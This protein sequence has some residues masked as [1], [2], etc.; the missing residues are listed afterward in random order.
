[1]NLIIPLAGPD[2]VQKNGDIKPLVPYLGKPLL[3]SLLRLRCYE[4][5][6]EGPREKKSSLQVIAVLQAKS[7]H[8]KVC[9][10]LQD[11]YPQTRFVFLS[12]YSQGALYSAV[13]GSSMVQDTQSPLIVDL[14]DIG[15]SW[16]SNPF[17]LFSDPECD[18][19]LPVFKSSE[20]WYSYARI[21]SGKILETREK[22]VISQDASAGVYIYRNL[23]VFLEATSLTI[24]NKDLQH[25]GLS[26]LCPSLNGV[27]E[28]KRKVLPYYLQA[29]DSFFA[30]KDN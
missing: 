7:P 9:Q 2:F 6:V 30:K 5:F 28:R 1:M 22:T 24:Q 8:E 11:L 23:Q 19:I 21:E 12:N 17:Q 3:Q 10:L 20:P 27:V 25:Q 4:N 13:A 29:V 26:Y 18:A 16:P 14:V 15:F